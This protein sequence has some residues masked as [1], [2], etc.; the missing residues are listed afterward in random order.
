MLHK[1]KPSGGETEFAGFASYLILLRITFFG[2]FKNFELKLK[3]ITARVYKHRLAEVNFLS[4]FNV[5]I[6]FE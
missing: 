1:T 2:I 5:K 4:C 3:I 6:I